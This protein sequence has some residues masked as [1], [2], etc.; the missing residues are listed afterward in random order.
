VVFVLQHPEIFCSTAV[1]V[2]S[3]GEGVRLNPNSEALAG[4]RLFES[5]MP[6]G[7]CGR[8][9]TRSSAGS[10]R[11]SSSTFGSAAEPAVH[12]DGCS[13]SPDGSVTRMPGTGSRRAPPG[14][15]ERF[16]SPSTS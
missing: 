3:E 8:K 4:H 6:I 5:A 1:R 7:V 9:A 16:G 14:V 11:I 12:G 10:D 15:L 13:N 2:I